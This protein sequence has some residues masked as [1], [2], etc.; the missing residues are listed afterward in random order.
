MERTQI[1]IKVC[2]RKRPLN[3]AEIDTRDP[4]I[5]QTTDTDV[6]VNEQK[7]NYQN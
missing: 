7:I 1:S 5:V 4:D 2:I 3:R 6:I